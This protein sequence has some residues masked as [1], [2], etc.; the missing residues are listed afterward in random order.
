[1]APPEARL[2]A[3]QRR[4]VKPLIHAPETVQP[5]GICG[6]GVVND[7]VFEHERAHA[8]PFADVG[9]RVGSSRRGELPQVSSVAFQSPRTFAPVVVFDAALAL[10]HF[11]EID[12]EIAVELAPE[13]G[14]PGK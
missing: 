7:L 1:M 13:R 14:S 12:G 6:I 3:S 8:R 9:G 10:L 11:G 5:A 4:A 2:V